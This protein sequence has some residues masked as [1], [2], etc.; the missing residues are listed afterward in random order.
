MGLCK[1]RKTTYSDVLLPTLSSEILIYFFTVGSRIYVEMLICV[2][3]LSFGLSPVLGSQSTITFHFH[4]L[5]Q[6][7]SQFHYQ[8]G[9]LPNTRSPPTGYAP[10][11][12]DAAQAC[13][14]LRYTTHQSRH[15]KEYFCKRVTPSRISMNL[16]AVQPLI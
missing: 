2:N 5:R 11:I 12:F 9:C 16:F 3:P 4:P 6:S 8:E 13:T 14:V 15:L 1:I 10:P 7:L